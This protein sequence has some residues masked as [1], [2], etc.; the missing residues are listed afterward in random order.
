M[1]CFLGLGIEFEKSAKISRSNWEKSPLSEN[2]ILYAAA[3]AW[4]GAM[5]FQALSQQLQH[6]ILGQRQD[7]VNEVR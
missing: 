5:G 6:E 2:Q 7:H 4:V 1:K 3:D